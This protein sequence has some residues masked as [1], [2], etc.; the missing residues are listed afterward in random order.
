ME[1]GGSWKLQG[2]RSLRKSS[3]IILLLTPGV[4]QS[5]GVRDEL[6]YNNW[7]GSRRKPVAF[8]NVQNASAKILADEQ[9]LE[10]FSID[11][12]SAFES[13]RIEETELHR[14]SPSVLDRIKSDFD[15]RTEN[16]KRAYILGIVAVD[17]VHINHSSRGTGADSQ[18]TTY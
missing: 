9:F 3:K 5:P 8:V 6:E 17:S 1:A 2:R 13:L 12:N 10:L 7:L 4:L 16:S 15:L 18:G 14:P 11:G